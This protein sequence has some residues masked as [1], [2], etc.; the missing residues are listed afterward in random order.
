MQIEYKLVLRK[1]IRQRI[2][3]TQPDAE[4]H[5]QAPRVARM[6][7]LAHKIESLI[8]SGTIK[9]Y[10]ELARV[11]QVTPSRVSQIL[12]LVQ[13]AP[14]IQERILFVSPTE[15]HSLTEG[16]LRKIAREVRWDRQLLLFHNLLSKSK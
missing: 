14:A 6:L 8:R 9:D 13:L 2:F 10:A 1:G 12:L 7:A 5:S 4:V 15:A 11:G 16:D 3:L